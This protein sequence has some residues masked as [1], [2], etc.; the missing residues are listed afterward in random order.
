ML[1][2]KIRG[3]G[4]GKKGLVA[5]LLTTVIDY[6]FS[7]QGWTVEGRAVEPRKF[8]IIAAPHTSNWDFVYFVGAS[9]RLNLHLSFMG[10]KSLFRWPFGKMMR[11]MGGIPVD[12]SKSG[13]YVDAMIAEFAKRSEFMLTIAPEGTR[14]KVRQWRTGFYHIAVGAGVPLVC[15]LMDYKRKVVG[16]GPAI[17]PTG[18]YAKDMEQVTAYYSQ[19]TPKYPERG[20]PGVIAESKGA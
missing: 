19:C 20:N 13:N 1:A 15:G 4:M 6:W 9:K 12:R 8:V 7:R 3:M 14:G 11:E 5:R 18:D 10:K 2:S 17:W 16:L